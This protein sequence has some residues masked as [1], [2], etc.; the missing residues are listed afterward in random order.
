VL[1]VDLGRAVGLRLDPDAVAA[2]KPAAAIVA[3]V[4]FPVPAALP[5][6]AVGPPAVAV[7]RSA[8]VGRTLPRCWRRLKT[9]TPSP[10]RLETPRIHLPPQTAL[11][12]PLDA[13]AER[14]DE[15]AVPPPAACPGSVG[16]VVILA[17]AVGWSFQK[18][19]LLEQLPCPAM[20]PTKCLPFLAE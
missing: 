8:H 4:M 20:Q 17:S 11:H 3:P 7:P 14:A 13:V 18:R 12:H 15:N 19:K 6:A 16:K 1:R 5:R 2:S 9:T 10:P